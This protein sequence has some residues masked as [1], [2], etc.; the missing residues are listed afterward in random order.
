MIKRIGF[1]GIGVMGSSMVSNLLKA[2]FEVYVYTRTKS[3]ADKVVS[4]GAVWCGSVAECA[5][6]RDAVITMVDF[7]KSVEEVYF[8]EGGIIGS[9]G[10]GTFLI[11]TTTTLPSLAEKIYSCAAQKGL[12][13]ID[14]PVS[15]GDKGAREATLTI[16]CGGD[17]DA[18]NACLPVFKAMGTNVV[19]Q[20]KAGCGQHTKMANQI[21]I[22][23]AMAGLCEAIAYMDEKGLDHEKVFASISKGSAGSK[24]MDLYAGRIYDG[25][26]EPGFYMKHF[27]KDMSIAQQEYD[28]ELPV[29]NLI[30]EMHRKLAEEGYGD[31]G[32]QAFIKYY[33]K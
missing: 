17:E 31:K 29:L 19:L 5:A 32:T 10:K 7:P 8:S 23:G 25:D 30:L 6:G 20:G 9:A 16:M 14:A 27:I 21:A 11:D 4:E 13:F 15:G 3:K 33:E 2:G 24:Q 28:G 12:S 26:F 22:A 18:F 1:I